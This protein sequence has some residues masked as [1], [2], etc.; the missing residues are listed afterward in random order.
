MKNLPQRPLVMIMLMLIF[1]SSLRLRLLAPV[2]CQHQSCGSNLSFTCLFKVSPL[3]HHLRSGRDD[4][5]Y[6]VGIHLSYWMRLSLWSFSFKYNNCCK[7]EFLGPILMEGT[8]E[9]FGSQKG[10]I[11]K[12]HSHNSSDEESVSELKRTGQKYWRETKLRPNLKETAE[13]F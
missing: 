2:W 5:Q 6:L 1:F 9:F 8:N 10:K 7:Y 4:L 12:S 3:S 11:T 13:N